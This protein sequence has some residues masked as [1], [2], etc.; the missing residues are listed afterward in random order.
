LDLEEGESEQRRPEMN[1]IGSFDEM[2]RVASE[3]DDFVVALPAANDPV[4]VETAV[5]ARREGLADFIL[6]GDERE[7]RA[8]LDEAGGDE[9]DFLIMNGCNLGECAWK[10]VELAHDGRCQMILKGMV[11]SS[12]LLHAVLDRR[13]GLRTGRLLSD[14]RLVDHPFKESGFL[15]TTDGGVNP[16]PT[17]AHKRQILEN[18]VSV[19]HALG[20]AEPK[21]AVLCAS[22]NVTDRM[23]HTVEARALR[24]MWERGDITGCVVDG[25]LSF[26]LALIEEAVR[27][28]GYESVVAGDADILVAPTIESG[29]F[30]GK[31]LVYLYGATPG[32]V[33]L[34]GKVPLLIPSRADRVEVK[35]NSIALGLVVAHQLS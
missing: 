17:L 24:E 4:S 26:D 5:R 20:Y 28:K 12:T 30:L 22:E 34:G 25:P 16:A 8:R 1:E 35:L 21:V 33:I 15:G 9:R 10:A 18:A 2:R 31:G 19:F 29:N 14:V 3:R 32:Q 6:L 7:I 13:Y 23:P 27:M 11:P